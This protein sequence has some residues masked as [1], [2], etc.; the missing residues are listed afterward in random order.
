MNLSAILEKKPGHIVPEAMID[1]VNRLR[2][3]VSG[4]AIRHADNG[5]PEIDYEF[6][7]TAQATKQFMKLMDAS[8]DNSLFLFFSDKAGKFDTK[9]D[10]QPFILTNGDDAM[11]AVFVEGDFSKYTNPDGTRSDEGNF[12]EQFLEPLLIE[13]AGDSK[14]VDDFYAKLRR[15]TFQDTL[16]NASNHRCVFAFLPL[17]GEPISFGHNELGKSYEWGNTS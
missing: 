15:K 8:K 6:A 17:T 16:I 9:K 10:V 5:K 3:T 2:G 11:L 13:T 7:E 14:S 4:F 12:W 1:H